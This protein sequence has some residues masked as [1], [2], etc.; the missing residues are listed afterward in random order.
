[1]PLMALDDD[2]KNNNGKPLVSKSNT[3][4]KY[5]RKSDGGGKK[6]GQKMRVGEQEEGQG[7]EEG[8]GRKRSDSAI[9]LS[10]SSRTQR[11]VASRG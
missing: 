1:M 5:G 4:R 8:R 11:R 2:Y 7:E 6:K 9:Q 3:R 10:P